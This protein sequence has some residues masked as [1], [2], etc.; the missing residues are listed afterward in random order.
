LPV[1]RAV[2]FGAAP[3][4]VPFTGAAGSAPVRPAP[5][6]WC[7]GQHAVRLRRPV[8]RIGPRANGVQRLS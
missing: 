5:S 6:S 7:D 1:T 2:M 8:Y 4:A 3:A